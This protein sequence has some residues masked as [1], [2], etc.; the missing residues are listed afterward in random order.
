MI[1]KKSPPKFDKSRGGVYLRICSFTYNFTPMAK[2]DLKKTE[3]ASERHEIA[4]DIVA[5]RKS[6]SLSQEKKDEL[7]QGLL[8]KKEFTQTPVEKDC[9]FSQHEGYVKLWKNLK[10]KPE[11]QKYMQEN[12]KISTDGKIEIIKMKKKFSI[13]QAEHNGKD[14]FTWENEDEYGHKWIAGVTYLTG[15]AAEKVCKEQ[16]KKLLNNR[17]EVEEFISYFPGENQE[18]KMLNFIN[19][20][21]LKKSGYVFELRRTFRNVG[22]GYV[23]LSDGY[24]IWRGGGPVFEKSAMECW[25]PFV[26]CE[27]CSA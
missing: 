2:K 5:I 11:Q 13:L 8:D 15:R 19:L 6:K 14:I 24:E 18:E 16:N 7:I 12:I 4:E 22:T 1:S 25:T 21:G 3:H 9:P 20:F 27:D 10:D 26:A 23:R 17:A